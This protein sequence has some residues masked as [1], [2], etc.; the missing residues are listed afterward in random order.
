MGYLIKN[1]FKLMLRNRWIFV[2]MLVGPVLVIA[3][4][5]SAFEDMM[6]S[7]ENAEQ[8]RAGYRVSKD[9]IFYENIGQ[10]KEAGKEAG[11]DFENYP[12]GGPEAL[13]LQ[14]DLAGFLVLEGEKYT[15][16]KSA[17][18]KSQGE[19]L[20]Y[21]MEQVKG[22]AAAQAR[23]SMLPP[24]GEREGLPAMKLAFMPE[25]DSKNYY[26]ITEVV[27]FIWCGIVSV[28]SVLA[29]EKKNGIFGRFQVSGISETR[30]YFARWFSAVLATVFET[31]VTVF[32][33]IVVFG[34]S[35]GT[36]PITIVIL[37]LTVMGAMAFGMLLY[38]V[39][40]N[41]AVTVVALFT[42]VWF[43][44]FFGGSF[45]TYMFSSVSDSLK[46]LSP[47]YHVNRALVECSCIGTSD[48]AVS[49]IAYMGGITVV[50]TLLAIAVNYV[51]KEGKA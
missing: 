22:Q 26:G 20:E 44:G 40:D 10:I 49:S 25:I 50:C 32:F 41:L 17:D 8:F 9:S 4:L 7:Y 34:I 23:N 45:E 3:L 18:Y 19:M 46:N 11:I 6:A 43:M 1:N 36:N 30:L 27:Y 35:W 2:T 28:A 51:K 33:T 42:V 37:L 47:I 29:S 12:D 24:A 16:Y 5:S 13:M 31:A 38:A 21:F 14:N 15:V 39:L 48:Y